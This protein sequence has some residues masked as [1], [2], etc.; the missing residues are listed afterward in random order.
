MKREDYIHA[1]ARVRTLEKQL[2]TP[3]VLRRLSEADSFEEAIRILVET[4]YASALSRAPHPDDYEFALKAAR[5][6]LYLDLKDLAPDSPVNRL[7]ALPYVYHNAKALIRAHLLKADLDGLLVDAV[8]FDAAYVKGIIQFPEKNPRTT[9]LE[10][11]IAAAL[12][13]FESERSPR[14]VDLILDRACAAEQAAAAEVPLTADYLSTR[15]DLINVETLLRLRRSGN[16]PDDRSLYLL[17]GG[18]L[19]PEEL[20]GLAA[21]EDGPFFKGIQ[22]L[23]PPAILKKALDGYRQSGDL[24]VFEQMR[25][26]WVAQLA[27]S[28][29]RVTYGP[30][31]LFAYAVRRE[32]EIQNLR[33]ILISAKNNIGHNRVQE[34]LRDLNG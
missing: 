13:D 20:A 27:V 33:I 16:P 21:A 34:R 10:Q 23:G 28:G 1:S 9:L 19:Q 11:S 24:A 32:T 15:L 30:E 12:A 3:A 8:E 31:V 29:G 6:R 18:N 2:L 25:D 14:R 5:D 7:L 4:P 22:A 26:Q 17:P